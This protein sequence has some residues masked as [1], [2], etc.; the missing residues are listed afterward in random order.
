MRS[1]SPQEHWPRIEEEHRQLI[2]GE[3]NQIISRT[4]GIKRDGSEIWLAVTQRVI[5]WHGSPAICM[6]ALDVSTQAKAE[7]A[8]LDN[9]QRLRAML[10]ILPV[11]VYI[12]RWEDGKILFVNRK[13]CLLFQQS[14][15]ILLKSSAADF[16]ADPQDR[17]NVRQLLQTVQDVRDIE[18]PMRTAQGREFVAEIAAIMI[19]YAGT[20]TVL[21]AVNDVTQRKQ[22]EARLLQQANTDELTGID[23]RRHFFAEAEQEIRRA[24]RFGRAVSVMMIDLDHF[25][26]INDTLGHAVGDMVLQEVVKAIR[27]SLRETDIVGRL[28]GE[29]FAALLP[30]TSLEAARDVATRMAAYIANHPVVTANAT[31]P[32]TVSIGLAQMAEQETTLDAMLHRADQALYRAKHNGRNRVELAE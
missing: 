3:K 21:V 13:T 20:P 19:H 6:T 1:L 22:L 29:E 32:C 2:R 31:V 23:N 15:G 26:K 10:E 5:D 17:A 25:K 27:Q 28:G 18:V 9:E 14:A 16:Y 8:M 12:A 7:Q 24:R 30:E 4:R 11:A